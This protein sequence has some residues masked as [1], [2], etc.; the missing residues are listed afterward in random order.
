MTLTIDKTSYVSP[1]YSDRPAGPSGVIS[2]IVLHDGEG[3][4]ASDLATLCSTRPPPD[5]RVSA[6]Y[7]VD[8]LSNVYQLVDPIKE[9]WHAGSSSYQGKTNWNT[10]S[11]GVETEHKS[12]QMWPKSQQDTIAELFRELIATYSIKEPWIAAHKWIATG[13]K[14]D[15]TDWPDVELRAW[16]HNLYMAPTYILPGLTG[17]MSCGQGFYD[18]YYAN[19][20]FGMWGYALTSEAKDIDSLGRECTWMRFERAV[21]KY[22][23]GEGVHLALLV[24]AASKKWLI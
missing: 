15:P 22:V 10:F 8:R 14:Y 21:Y 23:Y 17:P 7:Y 5:R 16:I 12:G 13:R 20:G 3:T 18:F 6:H 1:N 9:A 11:I 24:E 19:G 4:K 2:A